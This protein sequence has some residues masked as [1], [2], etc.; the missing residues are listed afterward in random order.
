M[1]E[2]ATIVSDALEGDEELLS[3]ENDEDVSDD[4]VAVMPRTPS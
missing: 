1:D 4:V 3:A 2:E